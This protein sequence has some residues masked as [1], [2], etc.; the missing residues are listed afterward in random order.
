MYPHRAITKRAV[1]ELQEDDRRNLEVACRNEI[2][3]IADIVEKQS[4]EIEMQEAAQKWSWAYEH[5]QK[6]QDAQYMTLDEARAT[7]A[8]ANSRYWAALAQLDRILDKTRLVTRV[9]FWLIVVGGLLIAL[10]ETIYALLSY[11]KP[12]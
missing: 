9:Q 3:R 2:R 8:V 12:N 11:Y 5:L 10:V 6:G 1:A 4:L 7:M